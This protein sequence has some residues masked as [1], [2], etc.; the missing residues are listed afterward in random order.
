MENKSPTQN[1]C[2]EITTPHLEQQKKIIENIS[3]NINYIYIV[4]MLIAN[5]LVSTISVIDGQIGFNYPHTVLGWVLWS[6][7]L[8]LTTAIG[9]MI[10]V[11]FRRQGIK[12]GHVAIKE[13]YEKYLD[14]LKA[15]RKVQNPRSLK[16]YLATYGKKDVVRKSFWYI[17]AGIGIDG[18][19]IGFNINS[20]IALATNIV[21]AV[22]FGINA[23]VNAEEYVVTEL[24]LWYQ[25]Q[26]AEVTEPQKKKEPAKRSKK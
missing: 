9:V 21:F 15:S 16:K 1:N 17:L 13:T 6:I 4:L 25:I 20:L 26:I 14:A 18:V 3:D 22:A 10:Y 24:V 8:V 23:M 12:L 7:K 19:L 2:D 11:A 5:I